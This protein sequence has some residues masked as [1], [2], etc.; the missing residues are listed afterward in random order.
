MGRDYDFSG[1]A[2]RNDLLCN[3]GRTIRR[4]A[5]K[6]NDGATVPLIWNHDHT[7]PEAVLGHALLENRDD[8]VYAY[9]KFNDTEAG[10]N[11]KK[12]VMHGDVRSLSIW[13]N[14]LKQIGNDVIHGMIRELSLVL[15]GANPGATIDFVMAHGDE[16]ENELY[17]NYDESALVL[18]HSDDKETTKGAEEM[19]EETNK[20]ENGEKTVKEVFDS[21]TEEQKTVVYAMIGQA[22]EEAGAKDSE[23]SKDSEKEVK[24]SDE[25]TEEL[26]EEVTEEITHS[27]EATEDGG[28]TVKEVFDELTE[29]QK[30]VVY[31]MIGQAL[32]EAGVKDDEEVE[33]SEIEN[34]EGGEG[35][36]KHNV[37]E[38]ETQQTGEV[39]SHSEM[40]AIMDD[41]K[42]NKRSLR[43]TVL[44]HGIE[45]LD[46][47][48]PDH[49]SLNAEPEFIKRNDD[50]VA[51]V[52]GGVH[53]TPFS[54]IK[55]IFADIT[56]AQARAKGYQKGNMKIEEVFKLLKRVT[57]PTT[58][59]KK[60]KLDRDDIVDVSFD[61]LPF[62]K[63]EIRMMLDEEL[64]RAFLVGD[65]RDPVE[66]ANDK[67]DE[68]CIRP[69]WKMEDLF[70]V[71]VAIDTAADAD[72]T[73]KAKAFIKACIKSRKQYKGS[74]N[75]DMFMSEDMLTD[76]LLIEDMN[77]RIIYDSVAKLAAAL[78]VREIIPV[79]VME[80]LTR[81]DDDGNTFE[82]AGIYVN[83]KDYNVGT[84]KGGEIN[85]FDDFDID[86]N[87]QKYLME[88][89]CSGSLVKPQSAVVIE[90]KP[91]KA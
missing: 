6:E 72:A 45:E 61:L 29:E 88:T 4:N 8:G 40:T 86:Y 63:K 30:T 71:K 44:A 21:M 25:E 85:F 56:A 67:I 51:K 91:A 16:G 14:K 68:E 41:A 38:N 39:L 52:L 32:E 74:G 75:P 82:L 36:M 59:Y 66:E 10:Q 24:H 28:K 70:T 79:P 3:D 81:T 23:D 9:C 83:L 55:T 26:T 73:T 69:I 84:D 33:H 31:A 19:A 89:R 65:G 11:A 20:T 60:Q 15:A 35:I 77:G 2:T 27:D 49:K 42:N 13:A 50:W 48:F 64:A 78:R 80:G 54:R 5:F 57:N 22:L 7:N 34:P 17:A 43:D 1:Y 90:F 58:V 62:L 12:L 87:Q 53:H 76:C 37:F 46:I 18:Y 47:M